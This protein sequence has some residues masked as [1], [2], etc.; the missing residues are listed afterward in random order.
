MNMSSFV[1]RLEAKNQFND[2]G[3]EIRLLWMEPNLC[4]E[5]LAGVS[6]NTGSTENNPQVVPMRT[7]RLSGIQ[8]RNYQPTHPFGLEEVRLVYLSGP[9]A[10]RH[11][12]RAELILR[13]RNSS[14]PSFVFRP[15]KISLVMDLGIGNQITRCAVAQNLDMP[16]TVIDSNVV[17]TTFRYPSA[18]FPTAAWHGQVITASCPAGY[19]VVQ[20]LGGGGFP[21]TTSC[22]PDVTLFETG[23]QASASSLALHAGGV[24]FVVRQTSP[25]TCYL[26]LQGMF[27]GSSN[28]YYQRW[29][30]APIC[31]KAKCV[32]MNL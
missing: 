14:S 19:G 22:T 2:L 7:I 3:D 23:A 28:A 21:G 18:N 5:S 10:N 4:T 30:N 13:T 6:L 12:A 17:G 27:H 9:F 11:F 15:R 1:R 31:I 24:E 26:H 16:L 25:T 8:F 32:R 20:C 29:H